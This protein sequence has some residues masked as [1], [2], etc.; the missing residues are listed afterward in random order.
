MRDNQTGFSQ[1]PN[2]VNSFIASQAAAA[3][4]TW[5]TS[6][7][8]L[9]TPVTDAAATMTGDMRTVADRATL[10]ALEV[11]VA[12]AGAK[13]ISDQ[14]IGI[15]RQTHGAACAAPFETG[16]FKNLVNTLLTAE[17]VDNFRSG[18]SNSLDAFSD[19][20]T[21]QIFSYFAEV[22]DTAVRAAS[23]ETHVDRSAGNGCPGLKLHVFERFFDALAVFFGSRVGRAWNGFIHKDAVVG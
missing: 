4:P 20:V 18:N 23:D 3:S 22:R 17:V 21:L 14:F 8:S 5:N 9:M 7:A 10:A 11:P 6:R 16:F 12:G 1:R 2:P 15:H 19:L 13:L